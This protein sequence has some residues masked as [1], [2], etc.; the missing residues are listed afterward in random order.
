MHDFHGLFTELQNQ[1]T[2]LGPNSEMYLNRCLNSG[3]KA[4][5]M[6]KIQNDNFS[7]VHIHTFLWGKND[8]TLKFNILEKKN[9]RSLLQAEE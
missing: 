5:F 2:N 6:A 8:K 9:S 3:R 7:V 4:L 1:A